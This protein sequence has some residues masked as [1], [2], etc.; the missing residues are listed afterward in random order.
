QKLGLWP[1]GFFNIKGMTSFGENV[2][3]ASGALVPV[4]IISLLPEPDKDVTGLMNLRFMHF[5]SNN[6]GVIAGKMYTLGADDNAFAHDFRST[7]LYTGLDF[8][9]VLDLFP[10]SAYGGGII[11]VPWGGA[12][13]TWGLLAP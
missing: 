8:N 6:F 10:F 1:G 12:L 3:R 7:F 11:V 4:S 13:S 2:D 9:M 5:L